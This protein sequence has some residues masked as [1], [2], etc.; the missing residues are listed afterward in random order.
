M[1][2]IWMS[3]EVEGSEKAK[4]QEEGTNRRSTRWAKRRK[5]ERENRSTRIGEMR[6]EGRYVGL[7][8]GEKLTLL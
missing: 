6:R 8:E 1:E 2:D 3:V 4:D 5:N 7:G